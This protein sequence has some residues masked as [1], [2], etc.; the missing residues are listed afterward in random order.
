MRPSRAYR[1]MT[2]LAAGQIRR[3]RQSWRLRV[4]STV[5]LQEETTRNLGEF[6]GCA[7]HDPKLEQNSGKESILNRGQNRVSRGVRVVESTT[8]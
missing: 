3:K 7:T 8:S 4:A 1:T 6:H 2:V 5:L